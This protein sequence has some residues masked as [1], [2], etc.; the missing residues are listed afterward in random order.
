[1][2]NMFNQKNISHLVNELNLSLHHSCFLQTQ[3]FEIILKYELDSIEFHNLE[4]SLHWFFFR[5]NFTN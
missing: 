4:V 1:M 2:F 3:Y 5:I